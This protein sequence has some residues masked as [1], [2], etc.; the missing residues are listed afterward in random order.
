[1]KKILDE[2]GAQL[3]KIIIGL[4]FLDIVLSLFFEPYHTVF[5]YGL[6]LLQFLLI[7]LYFLQLDNRTYALLWLL[8]LMGLM[9]D[10]FP[11]ISGVVK[12]II[13]ASGYFA[14]GIVI[15]IKA[16]KMS[17]ANKSFEL[18]TFMAGFLLMLMM[19]LP[20]FAEVKEAISFYNFALGFAIA[21]IIYNDNLWHRYT[22]DEKNIFKYILVM[23]MVVI[24]QSSGELLNRL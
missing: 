23:V 1:M 21:T 3:E 18:L 16:V 12:Y 15:M 9:T 11:G 5:Y 17:Q 19:F 14:Y 13:F 7:S 20:F 4:I 6:I 2:K 24:I 10:F 22:Q 8:F